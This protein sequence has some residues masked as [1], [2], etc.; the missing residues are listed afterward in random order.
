M[1]HSL[2]L[3]EQPIPV[4]RPPL[5]E[6]GAA[7]SSLAR[8]ADQEAIGDLLGELAVFDDYKEFS[9]IAELDGDLVGAILAYLLPYDPETLFIW[10]VSVSESEAD[11]GLA[12]LMLGQVMRR[13][14]CIEVTRVQTVITSN[15]ER[16]WALFRRFARWQRS[17]MDI[18][19]FFT[20]ALT[21][22]RR[23]ENSNLVTIR[24]KDRIKLA[25]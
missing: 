25:A 15:D 2:E 3:F 16:T 21:P 22:Y 8:T 24:L 5:P 9:V 11:K 7:V 10:Q 18:Q 12:S 20:Q 1:Q 6:D 17:R 14:A 4:L 13:E 23:H 19:P